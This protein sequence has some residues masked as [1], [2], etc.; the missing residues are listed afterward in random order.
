YRAVEIALARGPAA[1]IEEVETSALRGRGGAAF[2]TGRKLR[3]VASAPGLDK[4]VVANA[5][6]GDSGAYIDRLLL[7]ED[8]HAVIEG[9][10]VAGYAVGASQGFLF[11]RRE[12]ES[13]L[14]G[15]ETALEEARCAGVLGEK[16]L[17]EGPPFDVTIVSGH[18]SY[19]CGEETALLNS[20]EG[21]R[22]FVRSR[23]PYP[24]EHGL[25]GRPTLVQNVET[26]ANL[27]WIVRHG[28]ADYAALGIPGS[29]GTK[30]VSLNSLFRR[31]GL[32]EVELGTPVRSIVEDA[33]GG[34]ACGALKGVLIGGPLAGVLPPR[35]L[36]APLAFE[37]LAALGACVGHGGFIAFDEGTSIRELVHHVFSFGAYESCGLC[38]PCR[39]GASR[40]EAMSEPTRRPAPPPWALETFEATVAALSRTSL[41]GHGTGL[42][43]FAKSVLRY[44][45]EELLACFE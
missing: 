22:P 41:C 30:L 11:L 10:C 15:L 25:F 45:R 21:R 39:L 1:I 40:I 3:A 12:Y 42:G 2:P 31:P 32:Y 5:D 38:T 23:P 33:G 35:H 6:E 4:Y 44:Y 13:A 26:L 7:E 36:D 20:I 16:L 37:E 24:S 34:L 17:G 8:P 18:G 19:V 28:G 9:L 43:E 27:P 29:R 14:P